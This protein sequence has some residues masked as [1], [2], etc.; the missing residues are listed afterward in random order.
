MCLFLVVSTEITFKE[1]ISVNRMSWFETNLEGNV[2]NE[3]PSV[4]R[5]ISAAPPP[6]GSERKFFGGK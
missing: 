3:C 1:N 2:Q 5:Q 6:P 4:R